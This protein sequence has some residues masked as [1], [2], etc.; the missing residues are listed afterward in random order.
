MNI[1]CVLFIDEKNGKN[2][3]GYINNE[4]FLIESYIELDKKSIWITNL[5]YNLISK[6]NLINLKPSNYFGITIESLIYQMGLSTLPRNII[7]KE[8]LNLFQNIINKTTSFYKIKLNKMT[9]EESLRDIFNFNYYD[10][11]NIFKDKLKEIN[12]NFEKT[13]LSY[14][15]SEMQAYLN[16]PRYEYNRKICKMNLPFGKWKKLDQNILKDKKDDWFLSLSKK[17]HFLAH[18]KLTNINKELAQLIPDRFTNSKT[19][20]TEKEYLFLS[21]FSKIYIHEIYIC[22]NSMFLEKFN[23][24]K[25]YKARSYEESSISN[26]VISYN[27]INSFIEGDSDSL[28]S[29]WLKIYDKYKM[30]EV[31]LVFSRLNIKVLGYGAG[32][33]LISFDNNIKNRDVILKVCNNLNLHYPMILLF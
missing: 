32:S 6:T 27:Y 28:V 25:L 23:K 24:N 9:I 20:I 2:G 26:G 22:E 10:E 17:H 12:K 8:I 1:G 14:N 30:L 16:F 29:S 4:S 21:K 19:W 3:L 11:N 18:V 31:S 33:V 7:C 15:N 5:D 13:K